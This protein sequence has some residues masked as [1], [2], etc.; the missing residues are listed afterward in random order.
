[1]LQ[2]LDYAHAKGFVHRDI[3]PSNLLVTHK[4]GHA[5]ARLADF[6][7]ARTYHASR[8][9][10]LTVTGHRGGTIEYMALGSLNVGLL[11]RVPRREESKPL[12]ALNSD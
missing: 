5:V 12:L 2:A 8:I 3:K 11:S 1:M 6:G 10:G 9:S 7:L 4:H